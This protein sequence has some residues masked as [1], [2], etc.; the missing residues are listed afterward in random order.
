MSEASKYRLTVSAE[1]LWLGDCVGVNDGLW[2]GGCDGDCVGA[3][4]GC[5]LGLAV[6]MGA[7]LGLCDAVMQ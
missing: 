7:A 6:V 3:V 5:P 1:G 4:E 2:L